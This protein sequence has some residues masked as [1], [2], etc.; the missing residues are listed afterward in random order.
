M[1]MSSGCNCR[2][3]CRGTLPCSRHRGAHRVGVQEEEGG[4]EEEEEE[5]EE[6]GLLSLPTWHP[7]SHTT[8]SEEL[9]TLWGAVGVEGCGAGAAVVAPFLVVER[10]G[11]IKALKGLFPPY[12]NQLL[13]V[14]GNTVGTW[15]PVIL[16]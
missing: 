1:L 7:P 14:N 15:E 16:P 13:F 4:P 6:W 3:W 8:L 2:S 10:K 11:G 5:E 9:T 12:P